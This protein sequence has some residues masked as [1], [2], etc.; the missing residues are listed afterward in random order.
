MYRCVIPGTSR[1]WAGTS[2]HCVTRRFL[3]AFGH[4]L[5]RTL[6]APTPPRPRPAAA[7]LSVDGGDGLRSRDLGRSRRFL[8]DRAEVGNP[9]AF[10]RLVQ[11]LPWLLHQRSP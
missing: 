1:R 2:N 7:R 3:T 6:D 8:A 10:R 9:R 4:T 5:Y 11:L